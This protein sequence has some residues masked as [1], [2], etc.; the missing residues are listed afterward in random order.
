MVFLPILMYLYQFLFSK[1]VF[2]GYVDRKVPI[3]LN[4]NSVL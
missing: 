2:I 4:G 3:A 1:P